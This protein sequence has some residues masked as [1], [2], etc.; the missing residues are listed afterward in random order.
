MRNCE[1]KPIAQTSEKY[2]TLTARF[3]VDFDEDDKPIYFTLRFVDTFQFLN[4]SLDRLVKSI[5]RAS[6]QHIRNC[7][8]FA[9]L[10]EDV[11]YGKGVFPYSY[12][13]SVEK[14]SERE[15]PPKD[16]FFDMLSNSLGISDEDYARAQ[17]A[18]RGFHCET[19]KDY[20]LHYLELDCLLLAD[21]FE[22][23]RSK[24]YNLFQLD[25]ANYI[26]LPQLTFSAAFRSCKVDLL[27]Q[28]EMYE[29]FEQGIRGG[30]TFVNKH[31]MEADENTSIAYWDENNLY[32]GAL[33]QRL[34]CG[35]F[36]WVPSQEYERMDWHTI[37]TEGDTGYTLKVDLEYPANIHD[38]TQDFPLAPE[39]ASA[40]H[41]MFTQFN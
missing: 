19:F 10:D 30:M 31:H 37:N 38:K 9:T 8:E 16:A 11:I 25:A 32:G 40:A 24:I 41:E 36:K 22:N 34:P 26:T 21:V 35:E 6:M 18:W 29:F 4:G 15:L 2:I 20:M 28:A 1:L 3:V 5:D 13:D 23:F 39:P 12:L 17:R 27:T 7:Q 14:L 33:R